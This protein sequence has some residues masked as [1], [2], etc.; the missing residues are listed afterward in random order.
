MPDSTVTWRA[1][2][3]PGVALWNV[4]TCRLKLQEGNRKQEQVCWRYGKRQ[5][6]NNAFWVEKNKLGLKCQ[7]PKCEQEGPLLLHLGCCTATFPGCWRKMAALLGHECFEQCIN[8]TGTMKAGLST[9]LELS[10]KFGLF[11]F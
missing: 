10:K 5:I 1:T 6:L 9:A 11:S 3:H 2:V 7:V 8:H 4:N